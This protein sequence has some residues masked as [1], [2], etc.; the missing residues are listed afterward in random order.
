M[1]NTGGKDGNLSIFYGV[2]GISKTKTIKE[3]AVTGVNPVT[4]VGL[5]DATRRPACA[6][7]P[8]KSGGVAR[9]RP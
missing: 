4:S 3:L 2:Q 9:R 5:A 1:A 6:V 8:P 7:S